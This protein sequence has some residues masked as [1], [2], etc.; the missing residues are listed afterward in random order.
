MT[1][2][3]DETRQARF[4]ARDIAGL[5]RIYEA[6]YTRLMRLAP[7][8]A[9]IDC[10]MASRVAGALDLYLERTENHK[11]T[12]SLVLTYRFAH[13]GGHVLEPNARI[14]VYHDVRAAEVVSHCR[15]RKSHTVRPC[16]PGRR[17]ELDRRWQMNRFLLKW[18]KFCTFQGH[19]FIGGITPTLDG[20]S[21][22]GESD[23]DMPAPRRDG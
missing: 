23:A 7:D 19:L 20:V 22:I 2:R 12:T 17:P 4:G 11:Y 16:T 21:L 3:V 15:R 6:N 8:L 9:A 18:L 14:N 13:G 10:L 1:A 5:I